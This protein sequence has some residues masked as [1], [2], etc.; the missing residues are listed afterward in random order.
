MAEV[1]SV[2]EAMEK[3]ACGSEV[4]EEPEAGAC[5]GGCVVVIAVAFVIC[6]PCGLDAFGA[7][8]VFE[9]PAFSGEVQSGA[10]GCVGR[11]GRGV[12]PVERNFEWFGE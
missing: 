3:P 2:A 11:W 5:G 7:D 12:F 8:P 4:S 9:G 6:P 1:P 10:V